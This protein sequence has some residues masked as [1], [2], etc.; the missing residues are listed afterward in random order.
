[1]TVFSDVFTTFGESGE[2]MSA[3][4]VGAALAAVTC[5]VVRTTGSAWSGTSVTGADEAA[6]EE[7]WDRP[8]LEGAGKAW[9][10]G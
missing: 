3:S 10:A 5:A 9:F 1:M 4:T 7:I 2:K 8:S 6:G